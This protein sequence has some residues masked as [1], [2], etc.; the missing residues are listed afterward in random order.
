MLR[1]MY[2][3]DDK[4]NAWLHLVLKVH[5]TVLP[6]IWPR[7]ATVTLFAIVLT[8][9]HEWKIK[10]LVTLTPTPF[11]LIGLPL[12]IFLGFRN[13]ASYDRFWEGRK[14][15]GALVNTSRTAARQYL[16]YVGPQRD[17]VPA[18][19]RNEQEHAELEAFR[20]TLVARTI[21]FV[22]ALRIALRDEDV[23]QLGAYLGA[24]E[25]EE[26][27]SERNI[28]TAITFRT[29]QLVQGAWKRGWIHP[30]HL[31]MFEGTLTTLTD[32]HGA[33]ERIKSTPVPFSYIALIHRIVAVYC[34]VLPLGLIDTLHEYTPLAV[35]MV[36]YALFGLD[37]IGDEIEDPFGSDTNDLPLLQMSTNIEINLRQRMG[38]QELPAAVK[39]VRGV[40]L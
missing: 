8:I 28:T 34:F 22:H 31:G 20:K 18:D 10:G 2:V 17:G 4:K 26:L 12:G 6:R 27:R 37:A 16:L 14:L 24:A 29:G 33:C 23:G 15:W 1:R 32:I 39:P 7:V 9:L 21:A 38:E 30:W 40:L 25:V 11:T 3:V 13:S 36:S 35:A 19:P 5:G